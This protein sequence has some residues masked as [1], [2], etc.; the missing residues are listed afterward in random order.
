MWKDIGAQVRLAA[1]ETPVH[2]N[3]MRKQEFFVAAAGWSS[4]YRDAKDWLML[5]QTV[6]RDMNY[7]RYSNPKYDSLIDQSDR[8]ADPVR[9]GILLQEAEQITLDDVAY[10]PV[11]HNTLRML[12][13]PEVK[14]WINNNLGINRS[15]YLS[16][17]RAQ[18]SV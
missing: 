5:W 3:L 11:F 14:G 7:G 9:R 6:S 2:Y 1:A 15:R 17:D 12:I 8:T 16:L 18:P 4:D 13:S 10:A